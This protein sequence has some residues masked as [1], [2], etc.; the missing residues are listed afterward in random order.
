MQDRRFRYK[1]ALIAF[2]VT[3]LIFL[4]VIDVLI[5]S[6]QRNQLLIEVQEGMENEL[7]LI[8]SF[9]REPLLKDDYAQVEQFLLQW[10]RE[11]NNVIEI[12][13]TMPNS[14]V[15]AEYSRAA[16]SSYVSEMRKEVLYG[17]MLLMSLKLGKDYSEV[18][19]ILSSLQFWLIAFSFIFTAALGA[20]L[21]RTIR[22]MALKPLEREISLRTQ[23][24]E[25][26]HKAKAQLEER[27][28]ERTADLKETNRSLRLQI[29][30]RAKVEAALKESEHKF[31]A[32]FDNA[33]DGILLADVENKTFLSGNK[34]ICLMLGY[35]EEEIRGLQVTDI[36]PE[37]ELPYVIEQFDK[38]Y[39]KE[40]LTAADIPVKRRDGTIFYADINSSPVTLSG[41]TYLIGVFRD[42]T[43]RRLA[44]AALRESEERF[45]TIYEYAPIMI[46]SFNDDGRCTLWNKACEHHLGYSQEE[47]LNSEDPLSLFY[48]DPGERERTLNSIL[49]KDGQFREFNVRAK[50]GSFHNQM[51]ANF[52]LPKGN[53]IALGY[54]ITDRKSLETRL[55]HA[56][57]MEAVGQLAGGVA[58]DFNNILTAIISNSYLLKMK[59]GEDSDA[60][61]LV[62]KITALSNNAARI[63][64]ELLVFS[65]KQK[66]EMAC[67]DL[68][69]VIRSTENLLK[70][71]TGKKTDVNIYLAEKALPVM[72]DRNQLEQ[73]IVNLATNA[74]D[75]MPDG[76]SLTVR[77]ALEEVDDHFITRHGFG[78]SGMY[79]L[80]S[81]T[82]SGSGMS[83]ETQQK[84]FEPFFTS[85][86]VGKGT[87]LGLSIVY[88]IIEKHKGHIH[89]ESM[90]G[91]GTTINIYIP[92]VMHAD[93]LKNNTDHSA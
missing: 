11:H 54:D 74:R 29:E 9:V 7:D 1:R 76:G 53:I 84:V 86:E 26:L 39:R 69:E 21:W 85:K 67:V 6:S 68:N 56:Q 58:H 38:Q 27:V 41:R 20:V 79:A 8:A 34:M 59:V 91:A 51:W 13:A 25:M 75:A 47:V 35:G 82:D 83:E 28:R 30:E 45:R 32:I 24:E 16:Q 48:P 60:G 64:Q 36:H 49:K 93:G 81:V 22:T 61:G 90:L 62:D 33:M 57:K 19:K 3:L 40:I 89:M 63:V 10:A 72:A 12:R 70:E 87:G 66:T 77:T 73:V 5:V 44:E 92:L 2:M 55:F 31:R 43:A 71:F 14:F 37:E 46:D 52:M 23:A 88:G 17:D 65:R 78:T 42:I 15:L 18:E 4:I 80:L 50:D